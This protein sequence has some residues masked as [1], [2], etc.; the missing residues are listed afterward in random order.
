MVKMPIPIM[1]A[2]A[3][4]MEIRAEWT[5][6]APLITPPWVQKYLYNWDLSSKKAETELGYKITSLTEGLERTVDWIRK[7]AS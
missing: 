6:S 1:N 4:F 3:K 7:T 5:G 2:A